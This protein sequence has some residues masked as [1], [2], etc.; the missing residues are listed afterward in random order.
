MLY[1][2][3]T[4]S[5]GAPMPLLHS[6]HNTFFAAREALYERL[7]DIAETYDSDEHREAAESLRALPYAQNLTGWQV[8]VDG[9]VFWIQRYAQSD[10]TP[11]L[12]T[13]TE[14]NQYARLGLG[15][16]DP[17]HHEAA[18]NDIVGAINRNAALCEALGEEVNLG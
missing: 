15:S 13:L 4:T 6:P 14:I 16:A 11:F 9:I 10:E 5:N 1:I 8:K 12:D 3:G 18:L 2:V 17:K 7:I